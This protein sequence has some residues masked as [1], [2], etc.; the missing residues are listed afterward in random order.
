MTTSKYVGAA[1]DATRYEVAVSSAGSGSRRFHPP[2]SPGYSAHVWFD[3]D[4]K[5]TV[6]RAARAKLRRESEGA[7]IGVTGLTRD[8]APMPVA[9]QPSQR[10]DE[11]LAA[12]LRQFAAKVKKGVPE[13]K[14][15]LLATPFCN[16][17]GRLKK[18]V[19]ALLSEQGLSLGGF[20]DPALAAFVAYKHSEPELRGP[21]LSIA[22]C[23]DLVRIAVLDVG[24]Q[25]SI[26][27]D[28]SLPKLGTAAW[29][30]AFERYVAKEVIK[31]QRIDPRGDAELDQALFEAVDAMFDLPP[32]ARGYNCC[33]AVEGENCA[34]PLTSAI[35][36]SITENLTQKLLAGIDVLLNEAGCPK[37]GLSRIIIA[38]RTGGFGSFIEAVQNWLGSRSKVVAAETGTVANGAA[39]LCAS[40]SGAS[41]VCSQCEVMTA[42]TALCPACG[43]SAVGWHTRL[44]RKP[45]GLR[46]KLD[47][48]APRSTCAL[49]WAEPE[50]DE[51]R[52]ALEADEI[53]IGREEPADLLFAGNTL[54]S[55]THCRLV[56]RGESY[57]LIDL[58]STNGTLVNGED[59]EPTVP[60]LLRDG[61]S[62]RL[63]PSGPELKFERR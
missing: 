38:G 9:D 32:G 37:A 60:Q 39:I 15:V 22:L 26:L 23:E 59:L 21:V 57:E 20:V 46:T 31:R 42:K 8:A 40:R 2:D 11:V 17:D 13:S 10:S 53:V 35:Q 51:R 47:S 55:S 50:A 63:A 54:V 30:R 3:R 56:K 44:V 1:F 58:D 24:Q 41:M 36:A 33:M 4:G 48:K 5:V 12:Q 28:R 52:F 6:G 27:G 14:Q 61:D 18:L 62:I 19:S 7:A 49:R 34:V 25:W 29:A 16:P 43:G 45:G